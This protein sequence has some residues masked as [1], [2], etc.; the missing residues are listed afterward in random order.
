MTLHLTPS[1][2]EATY[3][4]LRVTPPF[5]K[6][7]LPDADGVEFHVVVF[8]NAYGDHLAKP[9]GVPRI[10]I[11]TK[12]CRKLTDLVSTMAHEMTHMYQRRTDGKRESLPHG[13]KYQRLAKSVCR[14]QGWDFKTF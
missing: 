10:R 8:E 12:R 4:M 1:I 11:C 9:N 5:N 6:W 2:L 7:G 3:E 13:P 14:A